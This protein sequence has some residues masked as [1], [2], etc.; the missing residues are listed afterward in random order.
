MTGFDLKVVAMIAMVIDHVG[1][2][3]CPDKLIFRMIGRIAYPLFAYLLAESCRN[4]RHYKKF[5]VR[6]GLLALVS[7]IPF[8]MMIG[9][10]LVQGLFYQNSIWGFFLAAGGIALYERYSYLEWR[11]VFLVGACVLPAFLMVDYGTYGAV[12]VVAFYLYGRSHKA[13]VGFLAGLTLLLEVPQ[14]LLGGGGAPLTLETTLPLWCLACAP[15]ILSYNGRRG[16]GICGGSSTSS[17]PP[18]CW[19]SAGSGWPWVYR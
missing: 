16:R 12:L 3:F 8:D 10:D 6:L 11:F 18:T 5:L 9:N 1:L 7:E 14:V 17:T 2:M 4:T 13:A 15:L 19:C